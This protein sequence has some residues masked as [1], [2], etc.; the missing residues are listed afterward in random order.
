MNRMK[1]LVEK[2][3]IISFALAASGVL[4]GQA[5]AEVVSW[6]DDFVG[7]ERFWAGRVTGGDGCRDGNRWSSA[8]D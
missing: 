4:S 2:L 5:L 7:Q 8:M 1:M 6:W 3:L